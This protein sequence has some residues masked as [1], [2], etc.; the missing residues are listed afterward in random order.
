[1]TAHM[2]MLCQREK[3]EGNEPM[4]ILC[5]Y[6]GGEIWYVVLRHICVE[7]AMVTVTTANS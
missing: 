3:K 7:I 4:L 6:L 2:K 1:M 5:F